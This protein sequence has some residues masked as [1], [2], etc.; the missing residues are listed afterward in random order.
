MYI[1]IYISFFSTIY[2]RISLLLCFFLFFFYFSVLSPINFCLFFFFFAKVLV[3]DVSYSRRSIRKGCKEKDR[4]REKADRKKDRKRVGRKRTIVGQGSERFYA[5]EYPVLF[6][7]F[8]LGEIVSLLHALS[9]I[10][11]TANILHWLTDTSPSPW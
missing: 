11:A 2:H 5:F 8:F 6:F 4:R 1:Y 7:F 9:R 3:V 10:S